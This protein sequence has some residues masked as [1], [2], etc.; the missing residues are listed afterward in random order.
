MIFIAMHYVLLIGRVPMDGRSNVLVVLVV[1]LSQYV[2][3]MRH[4]RLVLWE[5][6]RRLGRA[7]AVGTSTIMACIMRVFRAWRVV[8]SS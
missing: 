7:W 6:S 1:L 4:G 3:G 2:V 5:E 8:R